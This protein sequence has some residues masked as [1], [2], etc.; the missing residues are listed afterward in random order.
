[1]EAPKPIVTTIEGIYALRVEILS[2]LASIG[3]TDSRF[4]ANARNDKIIYDC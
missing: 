3:T 4:L 2:H 1:M